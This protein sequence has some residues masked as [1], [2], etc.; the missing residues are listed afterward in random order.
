MMRQRIRIAEAR[1][2]LMLAAQRLVA[3]L[4]VHLAVLRLPVAAV[5]LVA[6]AVVEIKP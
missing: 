3:R 5:R 2:I 1:L 6:A 4:P